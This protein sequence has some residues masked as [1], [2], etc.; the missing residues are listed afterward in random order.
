MRR[1]ISLVLKI[2][3]VLCSLGGVLLNFVNAS[4]DGYGRWWNTLL[5]FTGQSNIWLGLTFIAVL[6]INS[7]KGGHVE[8]IKKT[9]YIFKYIFTVCITITCIV[10]SVFLAPFA[11]PEYHLFVFSSFLTHIFAPTFAVIDFFVDEYKIKFTKKSA[12]LCVIPPFIYTV[13]VCFLVGFRVDF[14]RGDF[15]PYYFFNFYSPAGMFGFSL[16]PPYFAGTF[17]WV[18]ML[19]LMV[20]GIGRLYARFKNPAEKTSKR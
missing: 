15:F 12:W 1:K 8:K 17:Y 9:A 7:I 13:V 18:V 14:G 19:A 4:R 16:I 2:L 10:F 5:Y 3:V 11:P 20:F 6:I